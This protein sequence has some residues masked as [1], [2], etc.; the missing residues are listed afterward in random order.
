MTQAHVSVAGLC[1]IGQNPPSASQNSPKNGRKWVA[2]A[3]KVIQGHQC[4]QT[5]I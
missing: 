5:E 2:I 3:P 1:S 4:L